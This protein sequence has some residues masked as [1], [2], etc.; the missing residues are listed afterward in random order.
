MTARLTLFVSG[1][2]P[3]ASRLASAVRAW[4]EEVFAGDYRLDVFDVPVRPEQA[5]RHAV[6][7][8]PTLLLDA[9]PVRLV[10]DLSDIARAMAA[11]GVTRETLRPPSSPRRTP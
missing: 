10:G 7:A 6:L 3:A 1:T 4:C 11:L 8:T 5:R 9:P 2:A